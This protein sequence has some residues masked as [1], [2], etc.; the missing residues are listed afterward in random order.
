MKGLPQTYFIIRITLIFLEGGDIQLQYRLITQNSLK[1]FSFSSNITYLGYENHI[2]T[3]FS[4]IT[5][6]HTAI[7]FFYHYGYDSGKYF[8]EKKKVT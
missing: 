8:L 2:K 5:F 3:P 4:L 7:E 6:K 1:C